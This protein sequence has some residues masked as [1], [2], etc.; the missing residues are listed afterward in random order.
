MPPEACECLAR[1]CCCRIA[2][3]SSIMTLEPGDVI[4]TG[5]PEGVAALQ[6]GDTVECGVEGF[7]AASFKVV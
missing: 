2:H 7:A 1:F 3:I 5:T 6:P 4:C